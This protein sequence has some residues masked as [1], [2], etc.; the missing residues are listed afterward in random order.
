VYFFYLFK[1]FSVLY[2]EYWAFFYLNLIFI[3]FYLLIIKLLPK[4]NHEIVSDIKNYLQHDWK[5][6]IKVLFS[7]F[8][9][10]SFLWWFV[11]LIYILLN[12]LFWFSFIIWWNYS[13]LN[14]LL[15][16]IPSLIFIF[17]LSFSKIFSRLRILNLLL[18]PFASIYYL[19]YFLYFYIKNLFLDRELKV[20]KKV[21]FANIFSKFKISNEDSIESDNYLIKNI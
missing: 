5:N 11:Y 14:F 18:L 8:F 4:N 20:Y 6:E 13:I 16:L 2:N 15:F 17:W 3:L 9:S 21:P 7:R 19:F 1:N 10:I 12:K